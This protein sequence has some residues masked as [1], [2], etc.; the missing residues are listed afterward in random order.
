MSKLGLSLCV[1]LVDEPS[2][3]LLSET[4]LSEKMFKGTDNR[5]FKFIT[6]HYKEYGQMPTWPTVRDEVDIDT[7]AIPEAPEPAAYYAN[8]L[9]RK[10]AIDG[11]REW[12]KEQAKALDSRDPEA[13]ITAAKGMIREG[14]ETYRLGGGK[15]VNLSKNGKERLEAYEK[16]KLSDQ[17]ITGVRSLWGV[18]DEATQGWRPGRLISCVAR[19]GVGK[20]WWAILNA[21]AA[22]SQGKRVGFISPEMTAEEIAQRRDALRY[23]LPYED[24]KRGQLDA[25][26]EARF[27]EC[28]AK[29]E[30]DEESDFI[31]AADERVETVGDVDLFVEEMGVEILIVDGAYLLQE[32]KAKND[33]ERVTKIIRGLKKIARKRMIP[34]IVLVQFKKSV[35][36][37]QM[38]GFSEDIAFTDAI[39]QDSDIVIA[40]FQNDDMKQASPPQMT[41]RIIKNRDGKPIEFTTGWDFTTM[42]F[43]VLKEEDVLPVPKEDSSSGDGGG[44]KRRGKRDEDIPF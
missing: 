30:E 38:T 19:L 18:L 39:G 6:D 31:I 33:W 28:L 22:Q 12:M 2:L 35:K 27:R 15:L 4:G 32:P 8:A 36:T 25:D 7:A 5:V 13:V 17:G 9:V 24:F 26:N 23:K 10:A 43:S 40:L 44:K 16:L 37:G 34:I 1:K 11:Q 3:E 41:Q 29:A 14:L 42:D 20:T 21:D